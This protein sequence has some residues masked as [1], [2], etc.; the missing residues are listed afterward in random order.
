MSIPDAPT[1]LLLLQGLWA[2]FTISNMLRSVVNRRRI[3][4]LEARLED[5]P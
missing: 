1:A 5:H 2:Y 3:L 4:A